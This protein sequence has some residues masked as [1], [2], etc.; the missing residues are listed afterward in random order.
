MLL[1][2]TLDSRKTRREVL[3]LVR[4]DKRIR[5]FYDEVRIV[6]KAE[7]ERMRKQRES[8]K[9]KGEGG[10]VTD[11]WIETQDQSPAFDDERGD[12]GQ[13]PV[14]IGQVQG[15]HHRP[16]PK[17]MGAGHRPARHP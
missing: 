3:S 7:K 15:F 17:R 11:F 10:A 14:E 12:L 1:T 13:F 9:G 8:R 5:K 6:T 16:C 2:G 4:R